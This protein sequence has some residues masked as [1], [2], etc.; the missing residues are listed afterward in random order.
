MEHLLPVVYVTVTFVY[1]AATFVK[2][3]RYFLPLYPFLVLFAAYF[4]VCFWRQRKLRLDRM[5]LESQPAA[6]LGRF[7]DR[8]TGLPA[9]P[10]P[11]VEPGRARSGRHAALRAGVLPI[12]TATHPRRG[13]ALD[14][15]QS[16]SRLDAGE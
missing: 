16:P 2:F 5:R 6:R 13:L 8:G 10:A 9:Q 1:H 3:M 15:R 7:E 4:I 11:G 12:Y 14:V